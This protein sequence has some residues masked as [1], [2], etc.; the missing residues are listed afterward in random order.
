MTDG[1]VFISASRRTDIPAWYTPWFMNRLREGFCRVRNPFRPS[2]VR[3]VALSRVAGVFFWTR[4]PGPILPHLDELEERGMRSIF[5]VT[6]TGLPPGLEPHPVAEERRLSAVVELS[7]RLGRGR[8]WWR[9]DPIVLGGG[10]GRRHHVETFDRLAGALEPAVGRVTLSLLDWY[11]KT[12]RRMGQ[13]PMAREAGFL[14]LS[15]DEAEVVDLVGE[16][17]NRA[18]RSGIVPVSCCE[19]SWGETGVEPGAC[20][21]GVA[22]A[23]QLGVHGPPG[24]DPGQRPHCRCSPSIDIGAVDSCIAGCAYCYSTRSHEAACRAFSLHSPDAPDLL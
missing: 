3:E 19:T 13:T 17:G 22:F 14:R 10:L 18:R 24:R 6:V 1:P 2:Q 12:E 23:R 5:H 15:G 9:Y 7:R 4:W 11:R 8:V 20:I 16:L 21:D